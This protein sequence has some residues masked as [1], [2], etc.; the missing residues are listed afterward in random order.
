MVRAGLNPALTIQPL[1]KNLVVSLWDRVLFD[2]HLK[3]RD[4]P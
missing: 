1:L 3:V 2:E 4:D